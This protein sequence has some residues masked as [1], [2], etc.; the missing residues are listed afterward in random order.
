M[1]EIESKIREIKLA[2]AVKMIEKQK[3]LQQDKAKQNNVPSDPPV[4]YPH[5]EASVRF[6]R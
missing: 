1:P 3:Q 2:T 6:L 4:M 5:I